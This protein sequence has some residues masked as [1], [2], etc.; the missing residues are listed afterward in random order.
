MLLLACRAPLPASPP[1]KTVAPSKLDALWFGHA[2]P[3]DVN[4]GTTYQFQVTDSPFDV[5]PHEP[6]RGVHIAWRVEPQD[7]HVSIDQRGS[8]VVDETTANGSA[9]TVIADVNRGARVLTQRITIA[10]PDVNPFLRGT[11]HEMRQVS[12]DGVARKPGNPGLLLFYA[13]GRFWSDIGSPSPPDAPPLP[14]GRY[15]YDLGARKITFA[16]EHTLNGAYT[17]VRDAK[18]LLIRRSD[19]EPCARVFAY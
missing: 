18:V 6:A 19:S 5:I 3:V 12:C 7:G 16:S 1:H 17:F 2:I 11:W 8:I 13:D 15:S 4:A 14:N 10:R 9:Y